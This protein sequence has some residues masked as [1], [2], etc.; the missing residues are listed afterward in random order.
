[1]DEA[2]IVKVLSITHPELIESIIKDITPVMTDLGMIK[3]V[4]DK[5]CVTYK[6]NDDYSHK[7]LFIASVLRL[8]NPDA[9]IIEYKLRSGIRASLADCLNHTGQLTSYYISQARAYM[10]IKSF[11][12]DVTLIT[13]SYLRNTSVS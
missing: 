10:K 3:Q 5:F 4:Y 7:L 12:N 13:E 2:R 9:L 6:P 8:F 1:M 11:K